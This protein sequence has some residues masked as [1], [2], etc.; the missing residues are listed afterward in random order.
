MASTYEAIATNTLGSAAASVTFSSISGAYTDLVLIIS[1]QSTSGGNSDGLAIRVNSDTGANYSATLLRGDGTSAI[2]SRNSNDTFYR[3]AFY[4][5]TGSAVL[6]SF[7]TTI[8]NFQNYSNA[9][10]Y[11]T[12]L[13]R[14]NVAAD[15]TAAVVGLWRNTAAITSITLVGYSGNLATGS[16]FSLYGIKAA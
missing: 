7:S 2:S 9:T 10:T 11:K 16:T 4:G 3:I 12:L 13:A 8:L 5:Q 14:A 6:S 1:G 15:G